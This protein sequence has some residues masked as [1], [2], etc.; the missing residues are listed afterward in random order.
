MN[1]QARGWTVAERSEW[2]RDGTRLLV[3]GRRALLDR[4]AWELLVLA[5]PAPREGAQ[6]SVGA[7]ARASGGA[8]G[9]WADA[10]GEAFLS[11]ELRLLAPGL[12]ATTVWLNAATQVATPVCCIQYIYI[13][14]IY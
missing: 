10:A 5:A 1:L 9:C 12:S 7:R 8:A 14:C 11:L 13:Y 2:A 6:W 3:A 4:D